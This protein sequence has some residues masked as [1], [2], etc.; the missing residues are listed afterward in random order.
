MTNEINI[1]DRPKRR[2][3][4]QHGHDVLDPLYV[5]VVTVSTSRAEGGGDADDPGGDAIEAVLETHDH[6]VTRRELVPDDY[7]HIRV[8]VAQLV[9][10]RAVDAVITTGGTGVTADD[11]T[12]DAVSGLF[13]EPLP[14]F[15]ELFRWLSYE[16]VGTRA[17]ASRAIAG[18]S[19]GVPIFVLPGSE[20]AVRMATDELIAPEAPHLAGMASAALEER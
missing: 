13:D 3:T 16:E 20:S 12:A 19:D 5:G 17:M 4:D 10:D 11:V 8:T 9:G 6:A 15:G 1:I 2:G 14:G 7:A 18:I